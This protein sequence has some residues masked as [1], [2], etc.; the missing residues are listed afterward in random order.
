MNNCFVSKDST[1]LQYQDRPILASALHDATVLV[2]F[3]PVDVVPVYISL[4]TDLFHRIGL[5]V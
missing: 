1:R 5:V 4:K 2:Y 3:S